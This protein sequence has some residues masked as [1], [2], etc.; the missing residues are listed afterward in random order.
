MNNITLKSYQSNVENKQAT[1]FKGKYKQTENGNTYYHTNSAKAIGY[2][3]GGLR[4][5]LGLA[6]ASTFCYFSK[7]IDKNHISKNIGKR[8]LV[9]AAI[10][11][12]TDIIASTLIDSKRNKEVRKMT[13]D[14]NYYGANEVFQKNNNVQITDNKNICY[15]SNIGSK[16]GVLLGLGSGVIMETTNFISDKIFTKSLKNKEGIREL[17]NDIKEIVSNLYSTTHS[18]GLFNIAITLGCCTLGG[19]LLGKWSDSVANK[20]MRENL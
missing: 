20:K 6:T 12:C 2:S 11:A 17:P 13:N 19:W 5:L 1:S 9:A 16:Y 14:I 8:C 7:S 15:K 3:L 10:G 18:R 4:L